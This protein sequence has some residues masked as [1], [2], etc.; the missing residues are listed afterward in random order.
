M[1]G[2][3]AI[4]PRDNRDRVIGG[5][6]KFRGSFVSPGLGTTAITDLRFGK[7]GSSTV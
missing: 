3:S 7:L 1:S 4:Q 2:R 6:L 5:T